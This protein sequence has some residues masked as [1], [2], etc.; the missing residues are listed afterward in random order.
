MGV[1]VNGAIM[2]SLG[3]ALGNGDRCAKVKKIIRSEIPLFHLGTSQSDALNW[4]VYDDPP[5]LDFEQGTLM[6]YWSNLSWLFY[7]FQ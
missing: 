7:I 3:V 2:A 5:N 6:S 1:L 4:L